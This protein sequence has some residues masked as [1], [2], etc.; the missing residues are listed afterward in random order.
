[1]IEPKIIKV[2]KDNVRY[3]KRGFF[4]DKQS[5]VIAMSMGVGLI[6]AWYLFI[7]FYS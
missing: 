4:R 2:S 3:K 6:L 7:S 5:F 1:M